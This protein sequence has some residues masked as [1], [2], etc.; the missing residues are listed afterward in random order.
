MIIR[1]V[2]IYDS[3]RP[4]LNTLRTAL[5]Q[6]KESQSHADHLKNRNA[7]LWAFFVGAQAEHSFKPDRA[8]VTQD[9]FNSKLAALAEEMG[10]YSWQSV[11]DILQGF[12]YTDFVQ[13]H[14]SL[15]Y[16]K[17]MAARLGRQ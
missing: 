9:W 6:A 15:W 12:L 3:Q 10:L 2:E 13:P 1:G 4:I 17:T 8:N 5:S 11:R 16:W 14:A 7:Q